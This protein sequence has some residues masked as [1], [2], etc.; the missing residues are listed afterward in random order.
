VNAEQIFSEWG[1]L[2]EP[3]KRLPLSQWA[4]ENFYT[5]PEYSSTASLLRLHAYQ[6]E[7]LDC[8]TDPRVSDIVVKSGTQMLKTLLMQVALAYVAIEDPGPC[9]LSQYKETDAE[10]FS[11]ERLVPMIRDIPGLQRI[12]SLA[13]KSRTSGSTATYKEFPGGSWSLVGAGTAGNAARRSIRFYFGDEINKYQLTK[14][15]AFTE[16]AAERTATFGTRAKRVYCCSPTTPDGAISR[17]Y[18][19]SDQR[20]PW[21]PCPDCGEFQLLKWIHVKWASE[22][23]REDRPASARYECEHCGSRWDDLKRWTAASRVNWTAEKPFRGIAGF[24]DL[25]H[26][27]SPYK[28]LAKM[29]AKWLAISADKSAE[30]AESRRVF[31]NTNLAEEYVEK[32]E[33]P[34][35]QR[36]YDRREQYPLRFIPRGGLFVTAF[37]DVQKDRLEIQANAW[38][39]GKESWSIDYVVLDGNTSR[40]EVWE[41]LTEFLGQTYPHE[42]GVDL[43]IAKFGIDSGYA[44]QEVYAWARRQAPGRVMVTKGYD[45]GSA[46]VG[47]P[48]AVDVRADGKRHKRGVKVWPVNVSALKSELYGQLRLERPTVESGAACPP[49][50]CHFPE[51]A[52]EFFR[53]LTAEELVTRLVKGYRKQE[54]VKQRARNEALDTK[55]GN[56]AAASALGIDRYNEEAWTRLEAGIIDASPRK[57]APAKV[58]DQPPPSTQRSP[59]DSWFGGRTNNWLSSK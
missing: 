34:E 15:G 39:R 33:A 19:A 31:I 54:W 22:V 10:A 26:L 42:S 55:I 24:G 47:I 29:V 59:A 46:I 43:P 5:S 51:F 25:G 21:V 36:L 4:E 6:R 52:E 3:P 13:S 12:P 20:R 45:G 2:W 32:G 48:T 28:T 9:L 56:R 14:E 23:P 37:C 50:Y 27:Y 30:A 18:E 1:K 58:P 16:L 57:P 44:T 11:K 35:W 8:F 40:P 53:Q 7:P 38:G 41:K 17:M 49:G